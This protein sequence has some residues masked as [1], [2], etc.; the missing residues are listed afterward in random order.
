MY[1]YYVCAFLLYTAINDYE[2]RDD[3]KWVIRSR[4]SKTRRTDISMT[5]RN[6]AKGQAMT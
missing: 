2:K 6:R 4:K 5:K 3:T 1:M